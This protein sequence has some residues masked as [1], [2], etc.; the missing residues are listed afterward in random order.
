MLFTLEYYRAMVDWDPALVNLA[1]G[2]RQ[3]SR[4][5][6]RDRIEAD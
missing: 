5:R 2:Y 3:L 1:T 6:N 4:D